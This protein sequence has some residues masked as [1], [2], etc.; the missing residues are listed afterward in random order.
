MTLV[1]AKRHLISALIT[2]V[3]TFVFFFAG[4]IMQETFVL[5]KTAILSAAAGA[6]LAGI[7]A[8]AKITYEMAAAFLSSR[9]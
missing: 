8:V 1:N 9:K 2:F 7:R 5:S 6:L 4:L 3:A